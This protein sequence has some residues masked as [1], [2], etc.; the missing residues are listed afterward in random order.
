MV[1]VFGSNLAGIHGAGAAKFALHCKGAIWGIGEG[2]QGASYALPTKDENIH[3]LPLEDIKSRVDTF[4]AYAETCPWI[5]FKVT[6]VGC[7]LAGLQHKDIAPM[8]K[9]ASDNC[10]FDILWKPWLGD[11]VQYWGTF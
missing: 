9:N 5:E 11:D 6:C 7:G 1:F 8:F 2:L 10:F 4:L 3:T